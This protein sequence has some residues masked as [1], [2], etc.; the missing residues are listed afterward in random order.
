MKFR[1]KEHTKNYETR[2][3]TVDERG[4]HNVVAYALRCE[5]AGRMARYKAARR[6]AW[7]ALW[8]FLCGVGIAI[9]LIAHAN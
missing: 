8:L 3:I 5:I 4:T 9:A 7:M 2:I 6:N 1:V